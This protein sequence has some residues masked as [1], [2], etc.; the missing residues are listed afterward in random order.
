MVIILMGPFEWK[1]LTDDL[2]GSSF[3]LGLLHSC[4]RP[5]KYRGAV[6]AAIR[7]AKNPLFLRRLTGVQVAMNGHSEARTMV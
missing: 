4:P 1:K 7:K 5:L 6:T 2:S 3:W